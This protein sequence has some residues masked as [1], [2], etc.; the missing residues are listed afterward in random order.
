[1]RIAYL[2][3]GAAGMY[4]GTCLQDNTLA[5][6]LRA[7]GCDVL[8]LPLYTPIRTDEV[9]VSLER[10][11]YG[12]VNVY[13]QQK[14]AFFRHTPWLI[15]W[16][17]DRPALIRWATGRAV[18]NQ[19]EG[20]GPLTVSMLQG[21]EGRQRKELRKLVHWLAAEGRP[22][23]VVLSNSLLSGVAREI[24]RLLKVP[25]FC[26]FSSEDLFIEGIDEPHRTHCRRLLRERLAEM[27]GLIAPSGYSADFMAAYA[28]LPRERIRVVPQGLD[29][30]RREPAETR[31]DETLTIGYFTR[32]APEK[33][34]RVLAEAYR[35]LRHDYPDMACRLHVGGYLAPSDQ[36]Y[37]DDVRRSIEGWGFGDDFHYV[38]ETDFAGKIR[39]L[40]HL[41]VFSVPTT[42]AEPKGLYVLEALAAGVPVV[43]PRH[44]V[45]PELIEQTGGGV[46]FEPGNAASLAEALGRLLPNVAERRRLGSAGK[47]SVQQRFTADK[48]AEG[49]LDVLTAALVPSARRVPVAPTAKSSAI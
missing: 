36:E 18:S 19:P 38:G 35:H 29:F 21:E 49:M 26:R 7:R 48:M 11:F 33:G 43:Q 45:F 28:E 44:G 2:T 6:A 41:D 39:F 42:Y 10:V 31:G 1:M 14:S 25:V 4:C 5:A 9:N 13:L 40:N 46:L 24:R 34:L 16:L 32:I 17:L 30:T 37:F 12:G 15:D 3:A 8:L 47:E 20:L 27:D 22:D 23:V